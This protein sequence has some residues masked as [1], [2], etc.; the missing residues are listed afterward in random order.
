M[1]HRIHR[2][3]PFALVLGLLTALLWSCGG[4]QG[5]YDVRYEFTG[6]RTAE[7]TYFDESGREVS[8]QATPPWSY[9]FR[10]SDEEASLSVSAFSLSSGS[11]TVSILIDGVVKKT[12]SD[13]QSAGFNAT[14]GVVKLK[15]LL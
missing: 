13:G 4:S 2:L 12:S 11:A 6:T 9:Q 15:D 10:T 8:T 5:K 14:T 3:C 7:V 1:S